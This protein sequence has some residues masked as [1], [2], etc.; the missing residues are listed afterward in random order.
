MSKFITDVIECYKDVYIEYEHTYEEDVRIE[1]C[2]GLHTFY[3]TTDVSKRIISVKIEL[4]KNKFIDITDRLTIE[5]IEI[6]M[7]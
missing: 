3:D 6:L 4:S 1:E 2:H 5:E 7:D